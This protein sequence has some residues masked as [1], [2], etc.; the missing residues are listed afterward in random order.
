MFILKVDDGVYRGPRPST[1]EDWAL[2]K[3][4][5]IKTI[6]NLEYGWYEYFHHEVNEEMEIAIDEDMNPINMK[7]SDICPPDEKEIKVALK[8]LTKKEK[9][10]Y[11]HCYH[12]MDRTGIICAA[13]RI[14][15][16]KW[17]YEDAIK[18]MMDLGFHSFFYHDWLDILK[19]RY[20]ERPRGIG[21]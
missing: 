12:G 4:Q 17:K 9:P 8:I 14:E 19:E 10:I 11:I 21:R 5:N 7:V 1:D 15:I 16:Q 18:E 13:Y 20:D 2:L 6:L 3:K